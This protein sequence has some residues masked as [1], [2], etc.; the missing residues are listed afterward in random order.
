MIPAIAI[1]IF[2]GGLCARTPAPRSQKMR[3]G[4][5][6][7]DAH[8][9]PSPTPYPWMSTSVNVAIKA[10]MRRGITDPDRLATYACKHSYPTTPWGSPATWYPFAKQGT[11]E[12]GCYLRCLAR[13]RAIIAI[14]TDYA[15]NGP[16]E[17]QR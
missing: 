6:M 13:A 16:D 3:Y 7:M 1:G 12:R 11:H 10:G 8:S 15:V 17:E 2:I 4:Q 14:D 9:K 5:R